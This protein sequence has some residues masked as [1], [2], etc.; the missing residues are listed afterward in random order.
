MIFPTTS[1]A[2]KSLLLRKNVQASWNL[3]S[4]GEE[5]SNVFGELSSDSVTDFVA[6]LTVANCPGSKLAVV[7]AGYF[8][9]ITNLLQRPS[10]SSITL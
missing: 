2:I 3:L 9:G 5:S 7:I 10:A 4:T 6:V 8:L 1:S